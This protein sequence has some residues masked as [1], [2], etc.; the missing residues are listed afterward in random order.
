[1]VWHGWKVNWQAIKD[2]LSPECRR[3]LKEKYLC[4]ECRE[5]ILAEVKGILAKVAA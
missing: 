4:S 3:M 2:K 1:M 5:K